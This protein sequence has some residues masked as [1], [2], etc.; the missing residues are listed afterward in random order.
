[1]NK[2]RL[3]KLADLLVANAHNSKG[4]R[5]DLD[6]WGVFRGHKRPR[7]LDC[8]TTGCALGLAAMSGA[9]KG[10]YILDSISDLG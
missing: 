10:N 7:K 4:M 3:L 5:F 2:R 8:Q 1:M 9:F 6:H